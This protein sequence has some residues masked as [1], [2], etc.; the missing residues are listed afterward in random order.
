M[1]IYFEYIT[2]LCVLGGGREAR[3]RVRTLSPFVGHTNK[4]VKQ[5]RRNGIFQLAG[6][7][8]FNLQV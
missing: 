1:S 4:N 5:S 3:E 6:K 2:S 8:E 7:A